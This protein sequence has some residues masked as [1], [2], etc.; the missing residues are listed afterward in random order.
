MPLTLGALQQ[1]NWETYPPLNQSCYF[2]SGQTATCSQG[3]VPVYAVA[4]Q[5]ASQVSE[6]VKFAAARNL[7]LVIKN[8]G[9]DYLGRSAAYGSLC[10][11]THQLTNLSFSSD[12]QPTNSSGQTVGTTVM[13]GAGVQLDQLYSAVGLAG[14]SVV[15][16]LAHTVGVAGGYIQGGGHSPMGP[17]K[18]MSTDNTVEFEVVTAQVKVCLFLTYD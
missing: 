5:S 16:G 1:P 10:I 4:V 3:D 7:R 12:F 6:T 8:T 13:I 18:G 2:D 15:I 11:W 14:Q 17:W 9:H